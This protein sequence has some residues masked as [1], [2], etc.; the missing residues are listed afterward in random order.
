[1]E[2]M[3]RR[4]FLKGAGILSAMAAGAMLVGCGNPKGK[5][6]ELSAAPDPTPSPD[7][8][9]APAQDTVWTIKNLAEP[10]EFADAD[11]CI[12]ST[13]KL[14]TAFEKLI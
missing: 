11:V 9:P 2:A 4:S 1:M 3:N 10:S 12:G 14:Q 6:D 13:A 8:S 5:P 7:P